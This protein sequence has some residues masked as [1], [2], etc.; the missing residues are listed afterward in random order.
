MTYIF[1][2]NNFNK[3]TVNLYIDHKLF[4]TVKVKDSLQDGEMKMFYPNGKVFIEENYKNGERDG[5]AKAYDENGKL[6]QQ[7]TFKNGQQI[8]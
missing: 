8:K 4:A 6:L 7:A 3:G 5:V 2:D 1:E